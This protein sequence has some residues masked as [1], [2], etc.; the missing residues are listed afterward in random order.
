MLRYDLAFC[1]FSVCCCVI[2]VTIVTVPHNSCPHRASWHLRSKFKNWLIIHL[3]YLLRYYQYL[4]IS[5]QRQRVFFF[6]CIISPHWTDL[7]FLAE[8]WCVSSVPVTFPA[9]AECDR[10]WCVASLS[11]AL[12]S[13][14]EVKPPVF[15]FLSFLHCF[16]LLVMLIWC[17]RCP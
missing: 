16:M 2:I 1:S 14:Y 17:N 7:N 6:F 8:P 13:F 12:P 15:S 10:W 9:G 3:G 11:H 4:M 5:G